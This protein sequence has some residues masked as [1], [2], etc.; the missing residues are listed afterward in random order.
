MCRILLFYGDNLIEIWNDCPEN[1]GTPKFFLT[2]QKSW[3]AS[4]QEKPGDFGR[5]R[6]GSDATLRFW[7]RS[8]SPRRAAS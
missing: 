8:L 4:H 7:S 3:R 6:P 1:P 2:Y 5:W